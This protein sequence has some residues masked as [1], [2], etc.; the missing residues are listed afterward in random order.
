MKRMNNYF[1]FKMI[2]KK[3]ANIINLEIFN[4]FYAIKYYE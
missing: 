2:K 3:L 1:L 4:Y